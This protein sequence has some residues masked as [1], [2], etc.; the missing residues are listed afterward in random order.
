[1]LYAGCH[2]TAWNSHFST[3]AE[4]AFW[5]GAC[6]TIAAGGPWWIFVKRGSTR[7]GSE[8]EFEMIN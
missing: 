4:R 2:A 5:R 8:M 7:G 6:M 3:F 1:V